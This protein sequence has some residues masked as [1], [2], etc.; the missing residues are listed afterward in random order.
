MTS[1]SASTCVCMRVQSTHSTSRGASIQTQRMEEKYRHCCLEVPQGPFLGED[2]LRLRK[3]FG[4]WKFVRC[5]NIM[6]KLSGVCDRTSHSSHFW[7]SGTCSCRNPPVISEKVLLYFVKQIKF[8]ER[9]FSLLTVYQGDL[10][11]LPPAFP[12]LTTL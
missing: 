1:A 12:M 7:K 11:T 10:S 8:L 3:K 4:P 5:L 2:G 6:A 9:Q